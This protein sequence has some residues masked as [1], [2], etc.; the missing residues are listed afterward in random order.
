MQTIDLKSR[1]KVKPTMRALNVG[2]TLRVPFRYTTTNHL[3]VVA[4]EL[5]REEGLEYKVR[6]KGQVIYQLVTRVK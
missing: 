5:K 6:T 1:D 3:K 2:D 4:S